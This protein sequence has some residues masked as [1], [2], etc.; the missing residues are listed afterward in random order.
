MHQKNHFRKVWIVPQAPGTP[1]TWGSV[2][3]NSSQRATTRL[4]SYTRTGTPVLGFSSRENLQF[5][6]QNSIFDSLDPK[7]VPKTCLQVWIILKAIKNITNMKSKHQFT[8]KSSLSSFFTKNLK[9]S[10]FIQNS[11]TTTPIQTLSTYK[12][13]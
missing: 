4:A 2:M 13:N 10:I 9:F 6:H 1:K 11:Q 8:S 3:C 5:S 7:F 12:H